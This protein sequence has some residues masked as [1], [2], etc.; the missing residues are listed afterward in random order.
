MSATQTRAASQSGTLSRI[1]YVARKI[2]ADLL[3]I[4]DT[5]A[6]GTERWATNVM[7]DVR[8]LMDEEVIEKVYL[9]WTRPGSTEV[10][11]AYSYRVITGGLGLV[12]DRSGNIRYR[13]DLDGAE[14]HFRVEYKQRWWDMN[15]EDKKDVQDRLNLRWTTGGVLDYSSGRWSSDKMYSMDGFGAARP[16]C[17]VRSK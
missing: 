1:D 11:D 14:F 7:H 6:C 12:D 2:E 8:I 10:L 9:A 15:P 13:H 16:L 3:A 17:S 4:I 5:Y